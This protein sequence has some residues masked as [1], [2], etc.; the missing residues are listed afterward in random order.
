[1]ALEALI[2]EPLTILFYLVMM[3]LISPQLSMF[4]V[5][6][7]TI[8]CIYHWQSKSFI[9]KTIHRSTGKKRNRIVDS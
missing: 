9:K 2:K 6:V 7:F 5:G 1:M 3:V 4:L 8:Y